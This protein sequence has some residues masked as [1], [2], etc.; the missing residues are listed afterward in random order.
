MSGLAGAVVWAVVPFAPEAPFRLYAGRERD[1]VT[2]DDAATLIDAAKKGGDQQFTYLVAGKVRPVLV[3]SDANHAE[4]GEYIALRL[5]RFSKFDEDEQ[6][7]IRDQKHPALFHLQPDRFPGLPEE[8]AVILAGL[9]RL[10]RSAVGT[11]T[12]GRLD[13][14]ELAVVHQRF[15]RFH[16]F[17]LRALVVERIHELA[18]LQQSRKP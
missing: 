17:D 8:N 7:R 9:V 6:Q 14:E 18:A 16:D 15:A 5:A 2:V 11:D 10:H 4:M 12:L 1:P 13:A 3:I